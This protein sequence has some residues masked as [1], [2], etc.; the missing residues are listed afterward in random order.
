VSA[1]TVIGVLF[2]VSA[3]MAVAELKVASIELTN[4]Q[5]TGIGHVPPKAFRTSIR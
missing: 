1:K 5:G 3:A 2:A 4:D